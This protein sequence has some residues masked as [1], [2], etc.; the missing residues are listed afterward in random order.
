MK[1]HSV[2]TV[3]RYR[4]AR[5]RGQVLGWG[6]ALAVYAAV[7]VPF[8]GTILDQQEQFEKLID[9]YP[10]EIAAFVGGMEDLFSPTGYLDTYILSLM[11]LILG[12]FAVLMG[13][14]LLASDEESGRLDLIIAHPVSRTALYWGRLAAYSAATVAILALLWLGLAV[15][16]RWTDLGVVSVVELALPCLSL[17]AVLV[18]FGTLSLLFSMLLPSRRMATMTAGILLVASYFLPG[19]AYLN[20][21]IEPV[22]KLSPLWYYQGGDAIDSFKALW[23]AGL[24]VVALLFAGLAWWRFERRDIRVGGEGGWQRPTRSRLSRL[25]PGRISGRREAPRSGTAVAQ[26]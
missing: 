6:I 13:S 12:V 17:F 24:L 1:L 23:F 22:A 21:D 5:Y 15:P 18:L 11:P 19:L 4:F 7:M 2:W 25:L 14:G 16:S 10:K 9:A 20:G 26:R 8:Y 3:F